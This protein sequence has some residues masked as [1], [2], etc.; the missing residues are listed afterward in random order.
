MET[1]ASYAPQRLGALSAPKRPCA[2]PAPALRRGTHRQPRCDRGSSQTRAIAADPAAQP[3]TKDD[4]VSYLASGC[5]P[6]QQWRYEAH[7]SV[8]LSL[9]KGVGLD[10]AWRCVATE[11]SASLLEY[12]SLHLYTC[13]S[14][15]AC[16]YIHIAPTQNSFPFSRC[17]Y[18]PHRLSLHVQDRNRTRKA[19]VQAI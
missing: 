15:P 8:T 10:D 4:L 12:D 11:C 14:A 9:R 13:T 7:L 3:L 16:I 6:R 19:G 5:K 2:A 18:T 1:F 17:T